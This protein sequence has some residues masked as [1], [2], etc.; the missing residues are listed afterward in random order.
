[1]P[2]AF[3]SIEI[4]PSIQL[5]YGLLSSIYGRRAPENGIDLERPRRS[6]RSN[7]NQADIRPFLLVFEF[8]YL[9]IDKIL[10]IQHQIQFEVCEI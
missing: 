2:E 6:V 1:M 10:S 5:Q 7:L 4:R 9:V 3:G 8:K